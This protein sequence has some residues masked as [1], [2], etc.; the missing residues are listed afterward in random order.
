MPSD[1]L[2]AY[3]AQRDFQ[4][5][6]EP[7]PSA[8]DV[9][10]LPKG[11]DPRFVIQQHDATR[12]HWDLRLE[13]D[14]TLASWALPRGIPL[15]P[16]DDRLAVRTEDHP[17]DYLVFHGEIPAGNYGAGTMEIHDRGTYETHVWSEKKV[18]VTLHGERVAGRY[19]LHP[20][21]GKAG[22]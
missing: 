19:G 17:L 15:D 14:G 21:G 6:N 20:I 1:P 13:R 7:A 2:A 18:E 11:A 5:T 16:K 10:P 4:A 12:L 3:R 8:D 22:E 9:P